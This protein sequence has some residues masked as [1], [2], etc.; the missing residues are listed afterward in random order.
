MESK[1]A[2]KNVHDA[3]VVGQGGKNMETHRKKCVFAQTF[4]PGV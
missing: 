1:D 3:L 2:Q 4:V